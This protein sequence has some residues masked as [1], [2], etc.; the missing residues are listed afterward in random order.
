M[1]AQAAVKLDLPSIPAARQRVGLNVG[2]IDAVI[3]IGPR[4]PAV[5]KWMRPSTPKHPLAPAIR[6]RRPALPARRARPAGRTSRPSPYRQIGAWSRRIGGPG[7]GRN[8]FAGH[9]KAL[10]AR[11]T[12]RHVQ[13]SS[14]APRLVPRFSTEGGFSAYGTQQ[15]QCLQGFSPS[16]VPRRGFAQDRIKAVTVEPVG[17]GIMPAQNDC[18]AKVLNQAMVTRN[19]PNW[20][21]PNCFRKKTGLHFCVHAF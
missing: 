8:L 4:R 10:L 21:R 15:T 1:W 16:M 7:P 5:T 11:P 19:D 17:S 2:E 18:S 14:S 20:F 9:P 13:A 12:W 3:G 6:R